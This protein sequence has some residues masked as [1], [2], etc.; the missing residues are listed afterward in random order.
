MSRPRLA[1]AVR[2][3]VRI[4]TRWTPGDWK[5][6]CGVAA[7]LGVTRSAYVR[8]QTLTGARR[9]RQPVPARLD[10]EL[11]RELG[12]VGN[13]LNQISRALNMGEAV[14]PANL[15]AVIEKLGS[16]LERVE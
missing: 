13:N 10:P 15:E 6:V 4:V 14:K 2:R 1:S 12:R 16:L 5:R 3:D 8:Q 7:R 9:R 11:R